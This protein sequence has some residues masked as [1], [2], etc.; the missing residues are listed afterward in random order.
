[1]H[2][3]FWTGL[4]KAAPAT[5][6]PPAQAAAVPE[7]KEGKAASSA[8]LARQ[9]AEA[10]AREA[11]NTQPPPVGAAP[12][13]A[14]TGTGLTAEEMQLDMGAKPGTAKAQD[15]YGEQYRKYFSRIS[16]ALRNAIFI[17]AETAAGTYY[18]TVRLKV[19]AAGAIK[20][21]S[22]VDSSGDKLVDKYVLQ[23]VRRAGK[24]EAPPSGLTREMDVTLTLVR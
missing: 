12:V 16:W 2:L 9:R 11:E 24:V 14:A 18:A 4:P 20:E 10:I 19:D 15:K 8:E 7:A 1:V 6:A 23:G 22:R 21:H 3:A 13:P 5:Q 17:P